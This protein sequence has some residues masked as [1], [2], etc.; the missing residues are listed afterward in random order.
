MQVLLILCFLTLGGQAQAG[1]WLREKGA[2]FLSFAVSGEAS[3][4]ATSP[5]VSAYVEYGL[6]PRLTFGLSAWKTGTEAEILAF[7]RF[8]V[9]PETATHKIAL[10]LSLGAY[11]SMPEGTDGSARLALSW[12]RELQTRWGDGW[13]QVEGSLI[14]RMNG[15]PGLAKIEATAGLKVA[16]R[17]RAMF[18]VFAEK[19]KGKA[20]SVKLAPSLIRSLNDRANLVFG[21]TYGVLEDDTLSLS[22]GTWLTF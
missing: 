13:A 18:Q 21:V 3:P 19:Q 11:R 20:A 2:T 8:P 17:S 5:D 1:A 12:G 6:R 14:H 7:L 15:T 16:P 4:G 10:D 9:T 22:L